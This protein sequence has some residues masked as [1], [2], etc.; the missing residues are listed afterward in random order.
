[1]LQ[2]LKRYFI[3]GLTIFLPVLITVYVIVLVF[4]FTDGVLG[5][6][7]KPIFIAIFGF[8]FRGLSI[9]ISA[10]LILVIGFLV[11]H[12][13]GKN[14]YPFAERLLLKL[15]FFK[16]VYP[17]AKEMASFLF[18]REKPALKQVVIVE[19]PSKGIYSIG[20]L[21]NDAPK[22]VCEQLK[23]E[24]CSVLLPSSPSPFSGFVAFFPREDIIFT[25]ISVEG[26]IKFLV[27][28]GMV[29]PI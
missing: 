5:N 21:M 4:N 7:I 10:V 17:P 22:A 29:N 8:Y 2:R 16:Q 24:V 15:P 28:D 9:V 1:M 25:D 13:F 11:T 18:S 20:F 3:Y 12:F 6:L 14:L 26:A 19:Y 23:R 27:S